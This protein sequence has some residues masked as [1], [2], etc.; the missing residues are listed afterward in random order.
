MELIS[1]GKVTAMK[2]A[3]MKSAPAIGTI[4]SAATILQ[5]N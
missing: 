3:F 1:I 2:P 4:K 5:R